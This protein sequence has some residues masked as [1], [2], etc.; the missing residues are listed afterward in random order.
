MRRTNQSILPN[1]LTY[2]LSVAFV[3]SGIVVVVFAYLTLQVV[4]N[5]PV[6]P[7]EQAVEEVAGINLD[8]NQ[9][10]VPEV[11][12]LIPGQATPTLIPT[13]EPW[14]GADRITI[15]V[16]GIDRRPGQSFISRTDS[17]MLVSMDPV[18]D[19]ASILSIPRDLYVLIPGH[20]RDRINTAFVYGSAGDNPIG[21]AALAMQT[22]EYNLGVRVDHY[23]LVD[24]GAVI[25]IVDTLGGI[26]VN[27]PRDLNDP[28]YPDM[29]YGYDPLFIPAGWQ[30]MNGELALKYARTRHVDNDFGRAQRQQQVLLAVRDK[31]IGL[32]IPSLVSRTPILYQQIEQGIRTDLSVEQ[33]VRLLTAVNEVPRENIQSDVLD[34]RYVTSYRTEAGAEV[35]ILLNDETAPLIERLFYSN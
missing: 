13:N 20:G 1:W 31:A 26:E 24:F 9:S 10:G 3:L 30:T 19:T 15:L 21:G 25:S 22:V 35:L 18:A 16:M 27:V 23:A 6:N 4:L 5:R 14:Q 12:T 2:S 29:N 28:T 7:L 33:I 17:M 8:F 34:F 32:G 11:P